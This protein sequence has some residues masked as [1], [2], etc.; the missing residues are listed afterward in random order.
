MIRLILGGLGAGLLWAAWGE[1]SATTT[2]ERGAILLLG[3]GSL[4]VYLAL[5]GPT[6]PLIVARV[7]LVLLPVFGFA[8]ALVWFV[9]LPLEIPEEIGLP[10]SSLVIAIGV[11]FGWF[12]TWLAREY[13]QF[14]AR[15][16]TATDTMYVLRAEIYA[17]VA[18]LDSVDWRTSSARVQG[19]IAAGGNHKDTRYMPVTLSESPPILFQSVASAFSSLPAETVPEVAKFYSA[20]SDLSTLTDDLRAP[21]F[22]DFDV[23]M[24]V[25]AHKRITNTRIH[26]LQTGVNALYALNVAM[27]DLDPDGPKSLPRSGRNQSVQVQK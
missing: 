25:S 7:L 20:L 9:V 6:Y 19:K 24:R 8:A 3:A 16:Q 14:Q 5:I 22:I 27:G 17:A 21:D 10:K 4:A 18:L 11:A 15:R 12:S 13:A 1:A 23:N 26:A 2:S